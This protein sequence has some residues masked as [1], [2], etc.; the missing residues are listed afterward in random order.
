MKHLRACNSY[1]A[2][3]AA[4]NPDWQGQQLNNVDT[5]YDAVEYSIGWLEFWLQRADNIGVR[6]FS[7]RS[8]WLVAHRS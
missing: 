3:F 4:G 5:M 1:V 7:Q 6:P 8:I 2:S